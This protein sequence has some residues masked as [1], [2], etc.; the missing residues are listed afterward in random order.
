MIPKSAAGKILFLFLCLSFYDLVFATVVTTQDPLST[1]VDV[2]YV[3]A[4]AAIVYEAL[5]AAVGLNISIAP[6]SSRTNVTIVHK[7]TSLKDILDELSELTLTKWQMKGKTLFIVPVSSALPYR[8]VSEMVTL[9]NVLAREVEAMLSSNISSFG[10]V[11]MTPSPMHNAV[12]LVGRA[13]S[14]E[15]VREMVIAL[16][17]E[18]KQIA[19]DVTFLEIRLTQDDEHGVKWS[20]NPFEFVELDTGERADIKFGLI[21]R[22]SWEFQ[23]QLSAA[24]GRGNAKILNNTKIFV[25]SGASAKLSSG[26]E[27]PIITY[28]PEDGANTEFKKS[29]VQLEVDPFIVNDNEIYMIIKPSVSEITGR[30]STSQVDAPITSDRSMETTVTMNNGEWFV[31]SG[32]IIE[33][34]I[35]NEGGVPLLKDIPAIGGIFAYN[36]VKK[37]RTQMVVLLRPHIIE[38]TVRSGHAEVWSSEMD[39]G[40]F[41]SSQMERNYPR[42]TPFDGRTG[43]YVSELL[44]QNQKKPATDIQ[45]VVE[46]PKLPSQIV[47]EE[48]QALLQN[49][50]NSSTVLDIRNKYGLNQSPTPT[51]TPEPTPEPMPEPTP[52]P[53]TEMDK[54]KIL[55]EWKKEISEDLNGKGVE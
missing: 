8:V 32:L 25:R 26:E 35:S 42:K 6:E 15:L 33:R 21:G 22:K 13:E 48:F 17:Q 51:P 44:T 18:V 41:V 39:Q 52:S 31:I 36:N 23:G 29:G 16:D 24:I 49:R 2:E 20:W 53:V 5:A 12:V 40:R 30:I 27:T 19:I 43:G 47:D 28:D 45:T 11:K 55:E 54:T 1:L 50:K 10:D 37:E 46:T 3:N 9:K 14:V 4:P 7:G 34:A 38:K